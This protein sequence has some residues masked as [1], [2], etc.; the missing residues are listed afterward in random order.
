V[1]GQYTAWGYE[2]LYRRFNTTANQQAQ[3]SLAAAIDADLNLTYTTDD[4]PGG[5]PL[6]ALDANTVSR[7]TD[8]GTVVSF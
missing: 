2:H 6:G 5:I 8:G 3:K 7:D 1:A 4:W